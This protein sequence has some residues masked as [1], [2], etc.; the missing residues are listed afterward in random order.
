MNPRFLV[1]AALLAASLGAPAQTTVQEPWVRAT[2]ALVVP[3]IT[4]GDD[5]EEWVPGATS[6]RA[7]T[8]PA[9]NFSWCANRR[10]D[11]YVQWSG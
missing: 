2:V 9:V 1:A 5:D 4:D 3:T 8:G 10:S 11:L 6:W 7:V